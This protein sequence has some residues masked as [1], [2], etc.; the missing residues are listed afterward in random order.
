MKFS[1]IGSRLNGFSI[2]LFGVQWTPATS[3]VAVARRVIRFLED[4]RVLYDQHEVE[5]A[6][7]CISSAIEI[8]RVL[9]DTLGEPGLGSELT[10][11]L[12]AMR[13]AARYFCSETG[14]V[15]D[16]SRRPS[17]ADAAFWNGLADYRLNQAIGALRATIGLH[18]AA[19]AV[20]YG[21]DVDGPL[22]SILPA[23]DQ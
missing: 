21:I 18:V 9:T 1:E 2:P 4:R 8:R 11:H 19:L 20:R 13:A 7:H 10:E 17:R 12:Q 23:A 16:A 3:D 15:G 22:V 6:E 14:V 5:L